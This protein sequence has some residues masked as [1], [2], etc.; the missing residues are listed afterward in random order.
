MTKTQSHSP[1]P[2][3]LTMSETGFGV[4][5]HFIG[6][7]HNEFSLKVNEELNKANARHIVK[8]VN[9]HDAL[10]AVSEELIKHRNGNGCLVMEL[11]YKMAEEAL[12]AQKEG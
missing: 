4:E 9:S 10:V 12:T 11:I 1:T 6:D 8:C 2:W 5:N 7:C 3:K